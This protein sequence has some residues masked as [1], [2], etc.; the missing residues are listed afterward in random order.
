MTYR[1]Q[2]DQVSAAIAAT[3]RSRNQALNTAVRTRVMIATSLTERKET[4]MYA[5]TPQPLSGRGAHRS[6][7]ALPPALGPRRL[8]CKPVDQV[9]HRIARM[10]LDPTE[11]DL[12]ELHDLDQRLPQVAIDDRLASYR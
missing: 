2:N 10:A 11:R 3:T 4:R 9:I 1:D 8:Q 5:P 7:D 6:G 12:T